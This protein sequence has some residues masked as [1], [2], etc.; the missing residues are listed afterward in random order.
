MS[1]PHHPITPIPNNEPE[2]I[3][4]L[5][6]TRYVEIDANFAS[7]HGRTSAVEGEVT[8]ARAGGASL[9]ATINAIITQV[10]GISGALG[11]LASPASVQRAV[12]LDWL[13]RNRRIAFELFMPGY[14]LQ[15]HAGVSVTS[16]VMGDDSLDVVS[17]AGLRVG[18]DYLL[19]DPT[20]TELVRIAAILTGA[21]VRLA[22]NLSRSWGA[23]AS[24]TGS[25]LVS[26]SGATGGVS[27]QDGA[28]WVSRQLN[29]GD[30]N[31]SRAVVIRQALNTGGE[32][33]LFFRDG[34]T[35][36]WAER[37]W[38]TRRAG[39]DVPNGFGDFEYS[40]PMRGDGFLRLVVSGGAADIAHLVAL[41]GPTGLGGLINAQLRPA[42]PLISA[43]ASGATNVVETPTL[44]AA[45][46]NSPA[47][48]AF[49]S[50]QFQISTSSAF[51]S[52]LHDS[53][54]RAS[55]T[56]SLPAGVLTPNT[57]F[58]V[59]ARFRDVAGLESDWSAAS[60][61]TT[62]A[63]FAFIATPI[64]TAPTV[65]QVDIPEQPVFQTAAF[66][67]TGGADTHAS[68]QWQ[69]R[70]ATGTWATPLHDSGASTV[71]RLSF[72]VPAGVLLAGQTRYVM[73]V[74]HTGATLGSSEWSSDV[75]FTTRQAFQN[76]IGIINTAAGGGAGT[77]Q[78]IDA[79]FNAINPSAATF[80]N[81][82]TYAGVIPQTIDGQS[83]IRIP[84]FWYRTG[85]VPSGPHA[86][87]RFW[88]ISDQPAAGFTLHPAFMRAGAEIAQFWVGAFQGTD[89]GGTRL[90][91]A[92]GVS[93]LV[94]IDFPTM[95]NRALARNTAGVTGFGLW[96][97]Y[98]LGA[99]Q[100]LALIEMRGSDSQTLIGQGHVAG[101]SALATNHA[102]VAQATWRGIVGLWG[103]VWQMLDG[104]RTNAS[105][106]FE[107]WD[108]QGNQTYQSSGLTA[109][110]SGW[111]ITMQ[112]QD[113]ANPMLASTFIPA[114]TGAQASG[115]FADHYWVAANCV[116]YHGG[117]WNDGA[118]A[119]LF[120][121]LVILSSAAASTSIGG[122][123]AKV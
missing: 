16:G 95:R 88:M 70:L 15:N 120:S 57:T 1:L 11:S 44:S 86:G 117:G 92:A 74:R 24:L 14:S 73:R 36:N 49:A 97:P 116:A 3:P 47:G 115:T 119:G 48:N 46:F 8:A 122:R 103:N 61:F 110:A 76:I 121:L 12:S 34:H 104:L 38:S 114:T 108:A 82:P 35:L 78:S 102:T 10:G 84:R 100:V 41:G 111:T 31:T 63:S 83:M 65:E 20:Q 33:R 18:E 67:T 64:V 62:R 30:D 28:Q 51:A 89:D 26:N 85:L 6:N 58:F 19:T 56:H 105:S 23:S 93:P 17:T 45:N 91:S 71:H 59:R 29:L 4:A 96:D 68:S 7:L 55:T 98:Q 123:L 25:T 69:I 101:S 21:R 77:W 106:V 66:A 81:H 113:G 53:G 32:V 27:G 54:L 118:N 9:S 40:V 39:G 22:A 72:T 13:Y 42:A 94:S 2:A 43:P 107:V 112:G 75:P 79:Q 50:T 52:V 109:P 90:G 99:I 5:W 37:P 80:A 60:S 87:R